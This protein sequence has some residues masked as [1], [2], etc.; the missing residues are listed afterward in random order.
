MQTDKPKLPNSIGVLQK[1][2]QSRRILFMGRR[3][4][5]KMPLT[6]EQLRPA[7]QR[8]DEEMPKAEE[9]ERVR[10]KTLDKL[11]IGEKVKHDKS[12]GRTQKQPL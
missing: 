10:S 9:Y 8:R 3:Q 12:G 5:N 2:T 1:Y 6:I 11:T 7:V 4:Q